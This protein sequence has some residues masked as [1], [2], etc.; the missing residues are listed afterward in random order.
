MKKVEI[1]C[2][3]ENI[4]VMVS[5]PEESREVICPSCGKKGRWLFGMKLVGF[6]EDCQGYYD[7]D[8]TIKWDRVCG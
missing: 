3:D 2:P 5:D 7:Q 4:L 1:E 8:Y 6:S